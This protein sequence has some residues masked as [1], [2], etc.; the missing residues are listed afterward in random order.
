MPV[1]RQ[2]HGRQKCNRG[3]TNNV[4]CIHC[5]CVVAKDKAI[6]RTVNSPVVE[7]AAM[8]D[9]RAACVYEQP[10]VPI[11]S[12]I[13]DYCVSCAVHLRMVRSR[14]VIHRKERYVPKRP[15][16]ERA[17]TTQQ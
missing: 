16:A 10:V 3:A 17:A 15:G 8:D 11:M 7:S 5:G 14:C 12:N 13:E 4:R 9:L 2:N 1:K 6:S